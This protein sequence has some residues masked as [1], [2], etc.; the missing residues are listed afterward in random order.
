[1]RNDADAG[2]RS[3]KERDYYAVLG[4]PRDADAKTIKDAFR[5]LALKYHPDRNKEPGAEERFK[6]IAEAYAV[7]SDPQKRAAYDARGSAGVAGFSPED[8]VDGL[9]FSDLFAGLGLGAGEDLFERFFG[10]RRAR[11]PRR[12]ADLRVDLE[13]PL[14]RVLRGGE[15]TVRYGRLQR[16]RVC[17]GSGA[18]PGHPPAPCKECGGSGQKAVTQRQGGITLTQITTCPACRGRGR[19]I[20]TPCSGCGGTGETEVTTELRVHVPVGAE[21]GMVLRI[22]GRGMPPPVP[23]G[24][25]GDL[26]VV[27]RTAAD[28]RFE[29]D[30]ADLWRTETIEISD[31]VLGTELDVPTLEGS[32]RI[33]VPP[34]TQPGEVLRLRGKG[35]PTFGRAER[36]DLYVTVR[37][38]IPERL[39]REQRALF[40]QLRKLE[41]RGRR[42]K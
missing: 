40:E 29:R 26:L 13:I 6:E 19:I 32:L 31:A 17:D 27:L 18:A 5:R 41:R 38:H 7:L 35:L 10:R 25:P 28:A 3:D 36:G 23:G 9:D 4:V 37:V 22:E 39:S 24:E 14:E 2:G 16:C 33:R 12:G 8:L 1:M 11:R 21:D 30:G 20:D 15:E 34:G 42:F